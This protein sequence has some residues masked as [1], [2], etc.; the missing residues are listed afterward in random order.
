MR[1]P[2]RRGIA[3]KRSKV[4]HRTRVGRQRR[5][6]TETRLIEAALGV[7]AEKGPEAPVIDDFIRAA[8]VA[9]G[10]FYN[11]FKSVE[12]LLEATSITLTQSVVQAIEEKLS[13]LKSPGLRFG[14]GMRLLLRQ[15][16]S[17]P[18]W[19]R[20]V[21]R[22]WKLGGLELPMR[23]LEEGVRLK[24]F[25]V[26]SAEI[27]RDVQLGVLREALFRIGSGQVTK[28]YGDL[29]AEVCFQALGL[30]ARLI[31][32][33]MQQPLPAIAGKPQQGQ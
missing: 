8:G 20:F 11:H 27:A 18:M 3:S 17:D 2:T 12:E 33:I 30:E 13:G 24:V 14:V 15:A 29:V 28:G 23:D 16:E 1:S 26:P 10:T 4:D 22:V 19:C 9:R 5:A 6:R 7:F 32:E 21:A 25:R 31:T